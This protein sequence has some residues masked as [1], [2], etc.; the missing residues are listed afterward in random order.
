MKIACLIILTV[1][2]FPASAQV[3]RATDPS[4]L[5]W[6][7]SPNAQKQS[8]PDTGTRVSGVETLDN[9]TVIALVQAGLGPE[10]VIAKI[11]NS[12]GQYDT[13][14][15]A[16]IQLKRGGVPDGV[17]AAML[18]RSNSR[19][20]SNA[21][22]DNSSADPLIPHAPG[23]YLLDQNGAGRMIR[24]D[25]TVS[26][27]VKTGGILGYALTSGLA[28]I[29]MKS[30][31]PNA[32]ARVHAQTRRPVFYFYF[33]QASAMAT[34]SEFGNSFGLAATS[35]NEFSLVRFDEKKDHREAAVG[36]F[37][38]G[39]MKTGISDKA[40][41]SFSYDDAAP[42]VFRVTPSVELAPGQYG[43]VYSMGAGSG[44]GT[45]ARIFD[46]SVI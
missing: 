4:A 25:P 45:I 22:A 46:F 7:P 17:I 28:S 15:S 34:F 11:N 8:Q 32:V 6:Y 10:A 35:P 12:R 14:T 5:H 42:G 2:A 24:I 16:L 1:V 26:N 31:I 13:S 23:I 39:G 20:V 9:S 40:R 41:V 38:I 44:M 36:S 29:K 43:F 33:N 27:Q 18:G 3:I 21:I 30:I 37:S 19:T